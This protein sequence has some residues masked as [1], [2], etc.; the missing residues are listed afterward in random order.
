MRA[1]LDNK[2][3]IMIH[4]LA[5]KPP[6]DVTRDLW[7]KTLLEN[8]RV[9]HRGLAKRLEACPAVF[10]MAYWADA[11]PHHVPD[12]SAYCRKLHRQVDKVIS[13]R[14]QARDRFHVGSGE[15]VGNFFKDRGID[16]ALLL[17]GALDVKNEVMTRFFRETELYQQDQY[18]ADRMREPLETALR[19]A[20]D[21]GCEPVIVSHS[22]G[23]FIAYDVLWRFSH[24]KTAEFRRY[25]NRRVKMFVTMGSPLGD[26]T[27]RNL[28]FASY[29]QDHGLRRYPTNIERW[30]NYACLGDAVAHQRN[31]H[32]IFYQPMRKHGIFPPGPKFR[33][34]DYINLHNPFEV[35]SH[36]G[37]RQREKRNPHK[38]YGYLA[39]PRLGSWIADYLLDRLL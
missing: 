5:S 22:M 25:N 7:R 4:G 2:R 23:S 38:S 11:V 20:W 13:E 29:H 14:R 19:D 32:D 16:L 35:V 3:I 21:A 6:R 26:A 15:M 34:I 30:H 18:I 37:N 17:A 8:I 12:D 28:L 1:D 10:E 39:Q 31:F 27:I 33:S 9:S 24:R 36:A